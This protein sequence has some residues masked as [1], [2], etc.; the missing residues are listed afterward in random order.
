[1]STV[2][3][4]TDKA[5]N[6]QAKCLEFDKRPDIRG[7]GERRF[8]CILTRTQHKRH[9]TIESMSNPYVL[10]LSATARGTREVMP[11]A[12]AGHMGSCS[13]MVGSPQEWSSWDIVG[14]EIRRD[15]KA[16]HVPSPAEIKNKAEYDAELERQKALYKDKN[17]WTKTTG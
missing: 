4:S 15:A 3:M 7:G 17:D 8:R 13:Y 1:M 14:E 10:S 11:V 9:D 12:Q 6:K 16:R 5:K 2:F